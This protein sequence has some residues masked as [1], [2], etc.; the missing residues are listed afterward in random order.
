MTVSDPLLHKCRIAATR[1]KYRRR[2]RLALD[3]GPIVV[4]GL[5]STT[6]FRRFHATTYPTSKRLRRGSSNH[7]FNTAYLVRIPRYTL[8]RALIDMIAKKQASI[9]GVRYKIGKTGDLT[10]NSCP[11]MTISIPL[12]SRRLSRYTTYKRAE[13]PSQGKLSRWHEHGIYHHYWN[14]R[15]R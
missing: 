3:H 14:V 8:V 2:I 12:C 7:A 5:I 4:A 10:I 9:R 11:I 1:S 13:Q 15:L 6:L